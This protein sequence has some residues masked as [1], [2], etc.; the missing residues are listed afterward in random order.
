MGEMGKS[1]RARLILVES[2]GH[3][4]YWEA[5]DGEMR[6]LSGHD[7]PAD[8]CAR[9][10]GR[11]AEVYTYDDYERACEQEIARDPEGYDFSDLVPAP[12][13]CIVRDLD[14]GPVGVEKLGVS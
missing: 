10:P 14:S 8:V 7:T 4:R 5:Y 3:G 11:L 2:E 12:R 6:W 9:Y 13:L 1:F